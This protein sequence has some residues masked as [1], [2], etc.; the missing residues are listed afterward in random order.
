MPA[1]L[2]C[3]FLTGLAGSGK[4]RSL[5]VTL[6]FDP[7][8]FVLTSTTGLSSV[9]L[10]VATLNSTL[11]YYDTDS[12][13]QQYLRGGL[14]HTV[15]K[16]LTGE[17]AV[18]GLAIDEV[19]MLSADQLDMIYDTFVKVC[20]RSDINEPIQLLVTGDFAQLPPVKERFAFEANCWPEFE[21][22]MVKL[23]KV[24]RQDN[25]VFLEA[26][27]SFRKGDGLGGVELIKQCGVG[28]HNDLIRYR[29]TTIV[30][31]NEIADRYNKIL[32]DE[33]KN[34][35]IE[36]Y[37]ERTGVQ[38][39]DWK[40]PKIPDK[41]EIKRDSLV[42]IL[43]NDPMFKSYA[44]G[45]QGKVMEYDATNNLVRVKLISPTPERDG[46]E[47]TIPP[48]TRSIYDRVKDS[49][50]GLM[51][52]GQMEI[53]RITYMPMRL[54]YASTVHRSQGLTLDSVQIDFRDKFFGNPGSMYVALS[55]CRT[56]E[57]LR[58]VGTEGLMVKRTN[59]N[60]LV[61]RFL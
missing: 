49:F 34:P 4:S 15:R 24:W 54:A 20:Q 51:S 12:L 16:I 33:N 40:S 11:R 47:V 6:A 23:D 7:Q 2:N 8:S 52:E 25:S 31:T 13:R 1:D 45:D 46:M 60:P 43:A 61:R 35:L 44:N 18:K 29:G 58:L 55:R 57:G 38:S 37:A 32:F 22:N 9:N 48:V 36:I 27:N 17:S 3:A 19:S 53:G 39:S 56:P 42:M 14:Y 21:K 30:P 10:G 59:V 5:K 28:F 26:L 50:T 41:L